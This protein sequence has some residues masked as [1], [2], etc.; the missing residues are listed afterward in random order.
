[1]R[2]EAQRCA[3]VNFARSNQKHLGPMPEDMVERMFKDR[4]FYDPVTSYEGLLPIISLLNKGQRV[5]FSQEVVRH[6][7]A[8][9]LPYRAGLSTTGPDPDTLICDVLALPCPTLCKVLLKVLGRWD[10]TL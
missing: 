4:L 6:L 9:R 5:A 8:I 10:P 1:M 2:P 7:P 3:V